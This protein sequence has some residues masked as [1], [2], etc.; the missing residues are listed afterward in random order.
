MIWFVALLWGCLAVNAD[1]FEGKVVL[2]KENNYRRALLDFEVVVMAFQSS[3]CNV[4]R[5]C[6]GDF[7]KYFDRAAPLLQKAIEKR[8]L[9]IHVQFCRLMHEDV[10]IAFND[11]VVDAVPAVRIYRQGVDLGYGIDDLFDFNEPEGTCQSNPEL[12]SWVLEKLTPL[13]PTSP[14]KFRSD[15][16]YIVL[17]GCSHDSAAE[18][19]ATRLRDN[20]NGS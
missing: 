8:N 4:T 18:L 7:K 5:G 17:V 3:E 12:V 15:R 14:A 6:T 1:Y 11:L 9:S 13:E 16:N 20:H 19:N 2:L 10:P